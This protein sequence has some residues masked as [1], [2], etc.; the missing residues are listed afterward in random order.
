MLSSL[1]AA[2][3]KLKKYYGETDNI[4]G[5]LYAIGT[6]LAPSNKMEFFSRSDW[7]PDDTGKI[8]RKEYRESLQSLFERYSQQLEKALDAVDGD[9]SQRSTAPQY[10]EL[11]KYLQSDTI[12]GSARTF[13]K[14]HQRQFPLASITCDLM[15]IPAAGAGV[16][17]LLNSARDICHYRRGS[18]SLETIR[19]IMLYMCTTRFDI[20]EKQRLILQEY[21]LDHEIAASAEALDVQTHNFKATSDDEEDIKI[22]LD[23]P[24]ATAIPQATVD[25]PPL[26][27]IAA[28][29][30]PAVTSG[31]EE[32][33]DTN[34]FKDSDENSVSPLPGLPDTQYS[35]SEP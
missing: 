16:E 15:S 32:G 8:Y 17:R 20:K 4:E 34:E 31:D 22:R 11:T 10:D 30:R 3:V 19:D 28:G 25:A 23:I 18:L 1:E 24:A 35:A 14:D 33:S 6:I 27:A 26:S 29:K 5:N 21:R 9:S 13:W 12:K 7:D 2:K